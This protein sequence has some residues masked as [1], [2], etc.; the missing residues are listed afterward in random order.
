M[1][2]PLSPAV[3]AGLRWRAASRADLISKR[4]DYNFRA[5]VQTIGPVNDNLIARFEA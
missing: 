5:R 1:A 2:A 3:A 4:D